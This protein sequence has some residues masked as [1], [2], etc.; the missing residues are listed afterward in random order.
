MDSR[1]NWARDSL[2]EGI[3]AARAGDHEAARRH[4]QVALKQQRTGDTAIQ[5]WLWMSATYSDEEHRRDCL[6][7]ALAIDPTNPV[8]RRGL[9]TCRRT[10]ASDR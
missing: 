6:L 10:R 5:A 2:K 1:I 3:T 4:L 8:A 7:E 9:G